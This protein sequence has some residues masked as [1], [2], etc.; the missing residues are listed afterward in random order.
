MC[1][2]VLKVLAKLC[3]QGFDDALNFLQKNNLINC[4]TC[5]T[6]RLFTLT[7]NNTGDMA[8][9]DPS[10]TDCKWNNAVNFKITNNKIHFII[11]NQFIFSLLKY[12]EFHTPSHIF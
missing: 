12:K 2:T 6:K 7:K 3:N 10:C 5:I 11:F 1:Q 4:K 8:G 9:Y